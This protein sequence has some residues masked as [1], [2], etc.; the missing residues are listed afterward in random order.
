M[1]Y[2]CS[3][4]SYRGKSVGAA[5]E[6]PACGSFKLSREGAVVTDRPPRSRRLQLTLLGLSWGAFLITLLWKLLD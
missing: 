4:C 3:D 1:A 6:C 2:F 5:G